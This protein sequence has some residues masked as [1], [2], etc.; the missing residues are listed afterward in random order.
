MIFYLYL[1]AGVIIITTNLGERS[2]RE[3]DVAVCR[4]CA[5]VVNK[6]IT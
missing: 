6:R 3:N 4:K 1:D 5:H 2:L